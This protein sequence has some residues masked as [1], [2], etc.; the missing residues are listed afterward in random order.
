MAHRKQQKAPVSVNPPPLSTRKRVAFR[1]LA[2]LLPLL[3]VGLIEL[4]LRFCGLGGYA[5]MFRKLGPVPGGNLVLAEQGGASSWFFANPDRAG[6]SEQYTFVDPKPT[7]NVRVLLL[8]ESAMQGYPEPRHLCSSAFLQLM[9]QDAWRERQVEVINLGT[10]AIASFPVLGILTEALQYQPDLVVIY[11]GHNEFF[12]T[13]GVASVGSAGAHP[14]ILRANRWFH[15]LAVI[16]VL[17]RL[18]HRGDSTGNRTFMEQM[19]ARTYIGPNDSLRKAAANLLSQNVSEMIR[20]CQAKGAKVLI[21]LPPSN[22]RSL[23]P[24]GVDKLDQFPPEVQRQVG[25]L[26]STAEDSTHPGP[27]NGIPELRK[28]LEVDP[29]HARGHY[30]L[31]QAFMR[32][33]KQNEALE[34]FTLARDLDSMP[35]RAPSQSVN[36]IVHAA[37]SNAAICD[38]PK[39]FR[40]HSP[41]QAIGWELMDDHVHPTLR[42][43]ALI[44]EA[45]VDSLTNFD[46]NLR[47]S[48]DSRTRIAGWETYAKRLGANIYDQYAVAHNMRL[49]FSAP[50]MR[51]NNDTAFR[52]FNDIA[53]R[54]EKQMPPNVRDVLHE[55]QGTKPFEGSRCPATA[56]VA[57]LLLKEDHYKEAADLFEIA[58]R[59][60]PQY[61]SWYLEYVYYD[62]VCRQKINGGLGTADKQLAHYAIEQGHFLAEH[63]PSDTD[64][65][66]RYTGFLHFLCGEF[67]QAIPYLLAVQPRQTGIDRL[68]LDQALVVCYLET[69]Q[70]AKAHDILTSGVNAAGDYA[71]QYKAMLAQ[72]SELQRKRTEATNSAALR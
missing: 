11:L 63:M 39:V 7:N 72:L 18:R 50:F 69:Q 67:A 41:G 21:C 58:Q 49:L 52:R 10:T 47:I 1:L 71:E 3:L 25:A 70:P 37:T 22:E 44:A 62:L 2:S 29:N 31:G 55:W 12:G 9:L 5:P 27:S 42:G 30:F 65:T 59:A 64:F 60:V 34:Q 14:W 43:Q 17:Q 40:A 13:Y 61:S 56:A 57:Q 16:Q 68:A 48:P 20:R 4:A 23:A 38:L 35:W 45:I 32:E 26:L 8:G 53:E 33:G 66:Q 19:M 28:A 51:R 54:I 15:S 6:T 24:I 36:A 46:G